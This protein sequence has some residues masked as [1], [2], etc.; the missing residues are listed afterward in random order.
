MNESRLLL[1][2][3]GLTF[4]W[5][6]AFWIPAAVIFRSRVDP[7]SVFHSPLAVL[8]QTL[9]AAAPSLSA[10][11]LIARFYGQNNLKSSFARYKNWRLGIRWYVAAVLL[12]PAITLLSMLVHV[13]M[14]GREFSLDPGTPLGQMVGDLGV[15]GIVLL[16]PL[17]YL[18]QLLSSPLLEEFGWRGLALPLIQRSI[19]ALS[20]S[21]VLGCLW[22]LWHIPLFLMYGNDTGRELVTSLTGMTAL[23]VIM[24]WIF[25]NTAGSMVMPL[26]WHAS[27]NVSLNVLNLGQSGELTTAITVAVALIICLTAGVTDLSECGRVTSVFRSRT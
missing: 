17:I 11:F 27:L 24:T 1:A 13:A 26:L 5:G 20:S 22:W 23:T 3:F 7:M 4:A 9:G 16:M 25:N 2:F 8:L 18:S 19:P 6:W 14:R 10:M 12:Y 21:V 15:I